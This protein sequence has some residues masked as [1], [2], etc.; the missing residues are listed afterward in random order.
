[1]CIILWVLGLIALFLISLLLCPCYYVME[2]RI[3]GKSSFNI[4]IQLGIVNFTFSRLEDGERLIYLRVLGIMI[5]NR[6]ESSGS[7]SSKIKDE[8]KKRNK[9]IKSKK[10]K[11]NN[12]NNNPKRLSFSIREKMMLLDKNVIRVLLELFGKI[13]RRVKPQTFSFKGKLSF[14]DPYYTGVLAALLSGF[15]Q[16][17]I[18]PD[19]TG[20]VCDFTF[21]LKGQVV[22]IIILFYVIKLLITKPMWS[23]TKIIVRNR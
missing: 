19:F 13:L 22:L 15:S 7:S 14:E 21:K 8:N 2:G 23:I 20:E 1:M 18:E 17:A 16:A 12:K 3:K 10:I 11:D 5:I 6:D 4:I 9:L